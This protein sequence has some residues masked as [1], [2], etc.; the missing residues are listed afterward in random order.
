MHRRRPTHVKGRNT[1]RNFSWTGNKLFE[2]RKVV[3][4]L[5][6]IQLLLFSL[7]LCHLIY[8]LS[9]RVSVSLCVC[10]L[11]LCVCVWHM[12]ESCVIHSLLCKETHESATTAGRNQ[13]VFWMK[14]DAR[15][16]HPPL[17]WLHDSFYDRHV[18]R[19]SKYRAARSNPREIMNRCCW[20]SVSKSH[21]SGD[22]GPVRVKCFIKL[23]AA[24]VVVPFWVVGVVVCLM[25]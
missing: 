6:E 7:C 2:G 12:F 15:S 8:G 1:H 23:T 24:V 5:C 11:S 10:L 21:Q 25:G 19:Q 17:L 4:F 18:P 20:E 14:A 3:F 22:A 13:R 16:T 9:W